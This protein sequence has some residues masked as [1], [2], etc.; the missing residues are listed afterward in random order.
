VDEWKQSANCLNMDTSLFFPELG[1]NVP[2]FVREVCN[3]C[4]VIEEC[5]WYANE[6][7]SVQGVFGGMSPQERVAWR[8]KNN[9]EL[10]D[11]RTA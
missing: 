4:D 2:P 3:S 5:L 8:R 10:G 1:G 6:T 11:R 9:V 7:G